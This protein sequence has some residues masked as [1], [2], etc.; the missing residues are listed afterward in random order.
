[1]SRHQEWSFAIK[2]QIFVILAL[3]MAVAGIQF[4][5]LGLYLPS[6]IGEDAGSIEAAFLAMDIQVG[7]VG[8]YSE[9]CYSLR[10]DEKEIIRGFK[11][12]ESKDRIALFYN[13]VTYDYSLKD[14]DLATIPKT[15]LGKKR[16]SDLR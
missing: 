16:Q 3:M 13:G 10:K 8:E 1:M 6:K 2:S 4:A 9:T 5:A 15:A 12:A 11:I 7:C 14:R